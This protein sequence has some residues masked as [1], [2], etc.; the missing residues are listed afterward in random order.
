MISSALFVVTQKLASVILISYVCKMFIRS[1]VKKDKSKQKSY[2]YYRLT[3]S[4]RVGSKT[5][6]V[7]VLNLGKLEGLDKGFHKLLANRIEELVT[8]IGSGFIPMEIS[9]EVESLAQSFAKQISK[10]KIFSSDKGQ[11]ISKD[12]QNNF[13]TVDLESLEQ[14][15]S[16][17]IGGE[18]LV[19]QAFE[20]MDIPSILATIG[21]DAKQ[22]KV[23]QM[24]L[25]AKL[26][27]PSSELETQ[28][29]LNQN[30]ACAELFD[31]QEDITRYSLYQVT[32]KMYSE[33]ENIDKDLYSKT[34]NLFSD[35][36]KIVIYDLTNM[37]FEGQM[38]GS[39]KAAF[40]RSK[41]KRSDR[42]LIGLSLAID[43]N[44]FVRHSQFYTGNISEP[45][46]FKDLVVSVSKQMGNTF[47]KPLVI[48]DA[49]I[50]TEENLALLKSN[51]Y[52][53]DYICVSRTTPKNFTKLSENAETITDNR[54]NEIHLTKVS[55][56]GKE[57]HYLQI[58]SDQKKLKEQSMD[59]KL[60]QR[61]EE[62][63]NDIK[64]KL[65]KKGTLKK[66]CKIHEKVGA[67]KSKLSRVGYLYEIQ[68]VEDQEK[69]IVTDMNWKRIK[70][71]EK[72]KGE[73]FLRYTKTAIEE[74][75]IWD[76]YNLTRDVEAVFRCLKTDLNIR[77][78]H[79]QKDKYIEPHIWLGIISY[80]VVNYIGKNLKRKQIN[81]SWTK[82]VDL[83]KS[84]QSS[85][86]TVNNDKKEKLYIKL[87][88]RP[89]KTQKEIFDALNFKHRPYVRKTKVVTHL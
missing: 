9:T 76:A 59:A 38:N 14:V 70:E 60:T 4:Y 6:Q 65:Q 84:M 66:I 82:I 72:P 22:V 34:T 29:W 5:R 33:K 41:Q 13:Q 43:S 27:H 69:G 36:N 74:D 55:V 50:A 10:E 30:S 73:Y 1:V 83:M 51:E 26:L 16:K 40:G 32:S 54:G 17:E 64:Q 78:I 77:P 39:D 25:T 35:R 80:Q 21:L 86:N 56:P 81:H 42:K 12:V 52:N 24:L 8:G 18:W 47:E 89:T 58:K 44:G 61:L 23:A 7:V 71:K 37:Y 45:S 68:Y 79:H 85:L 11:L 2:T 62:Q 19:K 49:G 75:K 88:T 57:D 67:I 20:A 28:R 48:M 31:Y 15:E 63:L 87:C 3:H 46:T 53:Y